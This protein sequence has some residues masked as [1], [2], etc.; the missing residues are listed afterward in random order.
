MWYLYGVTS[1]GFEC[2]VEGVPAVYA[3]VSGFIDWILDNTQGQISADYT[4]ENVES[5]FTCSELN[6]GNETDDIVDEESPLATVE[7]TISTTSQEIT[8]TEQEIT[9]TT[10]SSGR[11][12]VIFWR[13]ITYDI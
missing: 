13:H 11:A 4:S 10:T 3:R 12:V 2:A 6:D 7:P 8:T 1:Y 9:E 5:G